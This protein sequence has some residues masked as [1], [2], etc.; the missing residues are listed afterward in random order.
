MVP[1]TRSKGSLLR[2]VMVLMGIIGILVFLLSRN[3]AVSVDVAA[4]EIASNSSA[5]VLSSSSTRITAEVIAQKSAPPA[6]HSKRYTNTKYAFSYSHTPQAKISE[7]DEGGGAALIVHENFEKVR[8]F[9]I[10]I[11]PYTESTISEE[12]FLADVPS[13]VRT[14]VENT[15]LDGIPA[16]TFVSFDPH[17]GETRE[18]WVIYNGHLYEI[19]TFRGVGDWFRPIIQ[20]WD[21]H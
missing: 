20:S 14:E 5:A 8:G 12:R 15:T 7:Y 11:V 1:S 19:T 16:V 9:Q 13:G 21:F 18:I 4:P 10:F 2:V 3:D 17:I 6:T